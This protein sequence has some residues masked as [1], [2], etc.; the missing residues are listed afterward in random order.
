M[1]STEGLGAKMHRSDGGIILRLRGLLTLRLFL[2]REEKCKRFCP[3][4]G[5][6]IVYPRKCYYGPQCDLPLRVQIPRLKRILNR[7]GQ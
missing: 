4:Y 2:T 7:R 3:Q 1:S 5:Q 6:A